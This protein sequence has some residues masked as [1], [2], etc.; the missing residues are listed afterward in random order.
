MMPP[1]ALAPSRRP[2]WPAF[3]VE[4]MV[5]RCGRRCSWCVARADQAQIFTLAPEVENLRLK[6]HFVCAYPVGNDRATVIT[7]EGHFDHLPRRLDQSNRHEQQ[8]TL[9]Q[10]GGYPQMGVGRRFASGVG[11]ESSSRRIG[12][13][14]LASLIEP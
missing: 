8:V 9:G 2:A 3:C 7:E 6:P 10:L 1:N 13:R 5:G 4:F 11:L 14:R 12:S